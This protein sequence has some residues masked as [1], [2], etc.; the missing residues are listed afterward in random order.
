MQ[1]LH[2]IVQSH[3]FF[4][5]F[6]LY[7]FLTFSQIPVTIREAIARSKANNPYLRTQRIKKEIFQSDITSAK[8]RLNPDFQAQIYMI[9]TSRY[10]ANNTGLLNSSNTQTWYQV[11]IPFRLRPIRKLSTD[12]AA[13]NL[14]YTEKNIME[15]ERNLGFEVSNL[16]LDTW[17]LKVNIEIL[18][19]AKLNIDT[20]IQIN[21]NRLKNQ[22]I[23]VSELIRTKVLSDQYDLQLRATE[24]EYKNQIRQFKI[25]TG[26]IDSISID[27][28]DE[29]IFNQPIVPLDSL[30]KIAL[31]N[32][33]DLQAARTSITVAKS[34]VVLQK[35][36]A[37]PNLY[38]ATFFNPQNA[39]PYIGFIASIQVP[40]FDRNQGAIERSKA[41]VKQTE[42]NVSALQLSIETEV[43]NAYNTYNIRKDNLQRFQYIMK[44]SELVLNTVK[45]KYLKGNTTIIDFLQAQGAALETQRMYF[46][47]VLAYRKSNLLLLY[48]SGLINEF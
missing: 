12:F 40:I 9:P 1:K 41:V 47:A 5:V 44:Q 16:W 45:Y 28:N 42:S 2:K 20:L 31:I 23:T 33:A 30:I 46:D 26:S 10:W 34:N 22:V 17:S 3:F 21:E 25:I 38:G 14:S 43:K 35:A 13:K 6:F 37:Y 24:Q 18:Q 19:E 27:Q 8:L 4:P 15:L 29:F 36:L 48:T 7:S 39:V 11:G 32:R